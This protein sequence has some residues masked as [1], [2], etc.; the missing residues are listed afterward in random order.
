[1]YI[2]VIEWDAQHPG[3]WYRWLERVTGWKA[4]SGDQVTTSEM[5]D[6]PEED[7]LKLMLS[8]SNDYGIIVQEA[9]II[10]QSYSLAR[11]LYH[12]LKRGISVNKRDG[13]TE[14]IRPKYVCMGEF[15]L[16][17]GG[18]ESPEDLYAMA[19]SMAYLTRVGRRPPA[20][21]WHVTC[22]EELATSEVEVDSVIHCPKCG[23]VHF[24]TRFGSAPRFKDPGGDLYQAWVRTRFTTGTFI[25]P[26]EG[27]LEPAPE[28]SLRIDDPRERS[29]VATLR[30]TP[31]L[32]QA[33][34]LERGIGFRS[35]DA[36]YVV[37]TVWD[38]NRRM[39]AR[40]KG[41]SLYIQAS[42]PMDGIDL[43]GSDWDLFDAIDFI[44]AAEVVKAVLLNKQP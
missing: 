5:A 44:G 23:S 10:C 19:R 15:N 7:L 30:S 11:M 8:R 21:Q 17:K 16:L 2:L 25:I 20:E 40:A 37:R 32:A 1:M 24:R 41:L 9:T 13:T 34:K 29:F 3:K 35:L 26:L 27:D 31:A 6:M 39:A 33:A 36:L 38:L 12:L 42:G 22:L 28:S 14:T 18:E 4:R 43:S